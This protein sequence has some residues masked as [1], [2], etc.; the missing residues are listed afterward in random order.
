MG[1]GTVYRRAKSSFWWLS[2]IESDGQR[3]WVSS[4]MTDRAAAKKTLAAL[5]RRVEAE[6]ATGVIAPR[7]LTVKRYAEEVWLPGRSQRGVV[8]WKDDRARLL[9]AWPFIGAK[10]L[11]DVTRED[12]V[13]MMRSFAAAPLEKRLASRTQLHV[14]RTLSTLFEDAAAESLVDVTPCTL[15]KRRGELPPKKDKDPLWRVNAVFTRDEVER[16]ISS[17]V[18]SERWRVT[19]AL[20][21]CTGVRINEATARRWRDL[22][23]TAEPLG[24]LSVAT[25]WRRKEHREAPTKT[26]AVRQVPV[27]PTLARVLAAWRL[28][29]WERE[30]GRRPE[31]EDFIL[32]GRFVG[33]P[34]N[35]NTTLEH[36]QEDQRRLGMRVR[37]QHD[38][39]RTFI[40]LARSN[41]A[42]ED[43]LKWVT[44]APE[45]AVFDGY[46]V[47]EWQ[48]LCE[49]VSRLPVRLL[50]AAPLSTINS[51]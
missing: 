7:E 20:I 34:V 15:L 49:Q 23:L 26:G 38:S 29:G 4:G 32:P 16:L 1:K 3:V 48:A 30:I 40:S 8:T 21:F 18:I 27:H 45:E 47:P 2:Y 17:P 28:S 37:S 10:A 14:Y 44:H 9:H 39:R 6:K 11:R 5:V 51:N 50:G 35:S 12:L 24:R 13:R 36:L 33:K 46:T 25:Q 42:R 41:G 43:I 22:D 19:Y 31:P